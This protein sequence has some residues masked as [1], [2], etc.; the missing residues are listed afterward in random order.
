VVT[1]LTRHGDVTAIHFS[2]VRSRV[3]GYGV[4]VFLT[5]GALIDTGFHAVRRQ[6][7]ALLDERR[8]AGVLVT[9]HHE[10]HAGNVELVASRGIPI[11]ASAETLGAI[12]AVPPIALYRRFVWS[13]M[14]SL[15]TALL[16]YAPPGLE[17]IH[18]PGHSSDHHVVWDRERAILFSADLF[19]SV[20]V[21]VARPG[22]DPRVL[23]RSLRS[24]AA[25]RPMLMLDAHRGVIDRPAAAL[26]A[27]AD[28]LEETIAR[29]D[30]ALD[31]GKPDRTIRN[32]VLGREAA[33]GYV[34]GG[35]L[36]RLNFVRAVRVSRT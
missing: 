25:L 34:S 21:R 22:E 24:A 8:P 7:A 6:L 19:L 12:R 35:E 14:P 23:V 17:L 18:A 2:T 33:V 15:R 1:R 32:E 29:I 26:H 27:K 10:D 3:A 20:K 13:P 30:R 11:A 16:D 28:W 36:S 9:H 5:R 31:A 4:Y